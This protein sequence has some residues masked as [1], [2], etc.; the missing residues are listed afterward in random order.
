MKR[1][2]WFDASAGA[3]YGILIMPLAG[4][5]AP[6]LDLTPGLM[7]GMAVVNLC[8]A[9]YAASLARSQDPAPRAI[10]ALIIANA[11]WLLPCVALAIQHASTAPL[12]AAF[13][14]GEGLFVFALAGVEARALR[15][16]LA[17]R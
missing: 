12:G 1:L 11:L 13:L 5:V 14:A 4:Y 9:L 7:R 8:Y 16:H 3:T 10:W 6:L 15:A 17:A 2:L